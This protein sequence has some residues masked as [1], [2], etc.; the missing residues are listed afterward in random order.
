VPNT[1]VVGFPPKGLN[2]N[3]SHGVHWSK[4]K[5]LKDRYR[6]EV[7]AQALAD[8]LEA[9]AS[10]LILLRLH[11]FPPGTHRRKADDDNL[12]AAFKSG[13]DGLALALGIDDQRF[14]DEAVLYPPGSH[15]KHGCVKIE[16]LPLT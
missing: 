4:L 7:W 14:R 1:I 13:R 3:R 8:K 10:E 9:P 15:G 6:Q 2:P 5:K 16:L 12:K 11:F